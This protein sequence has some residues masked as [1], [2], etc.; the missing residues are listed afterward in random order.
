M[1]NEIYHYGVKGMKWGVRRSK[2]ELRYNRNSIYTSVNRS[3]P[4]IASKN[5]ILVRSFSK[6]AA[7]QAQDRK[8][9][10]K[11]IVD[12]LKKPLYIEPIKFDKNGR[13]SKRFIGAKATVNVNPDTGNVATVWKTG[14]KDRRKYS[15]ERK[16]SK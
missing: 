3:I 2:E 14:S 9:S 7:D 15:S 5:G 4:K 16:N 6:H 8:V 1:N 10:A 11:D 13:P 12:A